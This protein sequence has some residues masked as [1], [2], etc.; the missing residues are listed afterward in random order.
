[1]PKHESNTSGQGEMEVKR[2]QSAE[3]VEH[4]RQQARVGIRALLES[5]MEEELSALV[6]AKWGEHS[7]GRTGYRNGYYQRDLLTTNGQ[8]KGLKVPRDR[9]GRY[10]TQVFEQYQRHEP[11]LQ[12]AV[13]E[14]Y[15]A[16][17]SV[18]QVGE[19][20]K[21]LTGQALSPSA[22]SR[23][24]A[25]LQEQ[26]EEWQKRKLAAHYLV[27]YLDAIRFSVRHSDATDPLVVLAVLAVDLA[28]HKEVIAL[29]ACGEESGAGWEQILNDV[30]SRGV[31]QVDVIVSDGHAGLIRACEKYFTATPR[32]RC[33]VHK[34]RDVLT[35]FPSRLYH[36]VR[37][38][39]KASWNQPSKAAAKEYLAAFKARYER[40]FPNA[41]ASLNEE[42]DKTLTF[43]DFPQA[44][45]RHIR[46][47]NPIESVFS[48]VRDR[49]DQIDTF[50][51]E[52]SCLTLVW[53]R[54]SRLKLMRIPTGSGSAAKGQN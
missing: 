26:F 39:L 50:T 46:T 49:T 6:G 24:N 33:V 13:S 38:E 35:Y 3:F 19:V 20:V 27:F 37:S 21:T 51:T 23:I 36:Q 15:V 14:M 48:Q 47:T 11:A 31:E 5:V 9:E 8:L 43:Y 41:I 17:A 1:M 53:A 34:E 29:K 30:R 54:I 44:L 10:Q 45:Q 7:E 2:P 42:L 32:Q 40:D 52:P 25:N 28:G 18:S 22:V 12:Q 4:L 16:G